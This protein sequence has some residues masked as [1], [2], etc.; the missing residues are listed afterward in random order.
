MADEIKNAFNAAWADGPSSSPYQPPKEDIRAIGSVIQDEVDNLNEQVDDVAALFVSGTQW[1]DPVA[2]ATTANI[3]LSGEQTIDG[4]L[5]SASRIL[6]KDQSAPAA[7][8]LY[9]TGPGAWSR[10]SDANVA[11][12]LLGLAFFVRGGSINGGKQ[13]ICATK[14][15]I[16]L[17]TTALAFR[18]ISDQSALN[19][20][21]AELEFLVRPIVSATRNNVLSSESALMRSILLDVKVIGARPGYNYRVA[22]IQN[23]A[24][25][26]GNT[27]YGWII[28]EISATDY[29]TLDNPVTRIITFTDAAP[30]PNLSLDRQTVTLSHSRFLGSIVITFNPSALPA[31]GTAVQ[32]ETSGQAGYSWILDAKGLLPIQYPTPLLPIKGGLFYDIDPVTRRCDIS[33]SMSTKRL[34][35]HLRPNGF[36]SLFNFRVISTALLSSTSW[37]SGW[38]DVLSTGTDFLPPLQVEAVSGG[39]GG[40]PT[41]IYTGG[42]HGTSG[43]AGGDVTAQMTYWAASVDGT[44]VDDM[45]AALTGYADCV[46]FS[47][48]NRIQAYNTIVSNREVIEQRIVMR[49]YPGSFECVVQYEALEAIV[50]RLENGFQA[51]TNNDGTAPYDGNAFGDSV[52]FLEGVL[53]DRETIISGDM[54][55]GTKTTAPNAWAAVARGPAGDMVSWI[56]RAFGVGGLQNVS[57]SSSSV[58]MSGKKMYQAVVGG[59]SGL[60]LSAGDVIEYRGGYAFSEAGA[61]SGADVDCGFRIYK[62]GVPH[63][64][65]AILNA[66]GGFVATL[67]EHAGREIDAGDRPII[68][69]HAKW[70]VSALGYDV[71]T[72]RVAS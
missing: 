2:V 27:G 52:H 17:G 72:G 39:D 16:I 54:S 49:C 37:T 60:A 21:Y 57:A 25:R 22:Y 61:V 12:E 11:T 20:D 23:G 18:E 40:S 44:R 29:A 1:T 48:V 43:G 14:A 59:G 15:P 8:G 19:A 69:P 53:Q 5:T 62:N 71:L 7:N 35:A 65:A 50:I 31:A 13:F 9:L 6:V 26:S 68:D 4:V 10:A 28:E 34:K 32:S 58:R 45:T 70:A 55:A 3:T 42:N 33:F 24:T 38:T 67:T 63:Y 56:D 46:T 36:N 41:Q 30:A 64:V 51:L 66:G 47:W